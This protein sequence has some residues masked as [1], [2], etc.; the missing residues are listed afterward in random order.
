[1]SLVF[2]TAAKRTQPITFMLDGEEYIFTPG[3]RAGIILEALEGEEGQ[4]QIAVA[5]GLVRWVFDGLGPERS[6]KL[7]ARLKDAG[8]EFDLDDLTSMG[9]KLLEATSGRPLGKSSESQASP[10]T[11]GKPS[12]ISDSS[13]DSTPSNSP[14]TD[15]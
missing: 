4:A 5:S 6:E 11:T 12:S 3:K 14:S 10:E 1:M 7:R 15:S 9:S 13:K 8:D 2:D